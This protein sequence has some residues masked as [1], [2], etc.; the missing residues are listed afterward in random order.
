M[1]PATE[2]PSFKL[3]IPDETADDV[4]EALGGFGDSVD[5]P[6]L[7]IKV[8]AEYYTKY[9]DESGRPVFS[10]G[11][12]FVT[13]GGEPTPAQRTLDVVDSF[14]VAVRLSLATIGFARVFKR[15]VTRD[16]LRQEVE[17]LEAMAST[18]LSAAMIG[19]LRSFS[20][21]LYDANSFEGANLCRTANQGGLP[22]TKIVDH[23]KRVLRDL[24]ASL[25]D[26]TLGIGQAADLDNPNRLFECGWSWG[27]V[28]GAPPVKTTAEVGSQP[29][30]VAEDAP[31]LY[32]TVVALD[33][34][35]E[36]FSD[37]TR[38][39]GLLN[40][41]QGRL[42]RSLQA[43]WDITQRYWSRIA[44]FGDGRWPLE[45]IPWRTTDGV[46]SDY[47][48]LL[49]SSIVIQD[50]S[51][52]RASEADEGDLSRV[53]KVLE[54][55]AARARIT[56]REV[57]GGDS[58][59]A[60]HVPGFSLELV[61]SE[62]DG[63]QRLGWVLSDFSPQLLGSTIRV[64]GLLRTAALRGQLIELADDVWFRH[65]ARRR[66]KSQLWDQPGGIYSGIEST[67]EKPTWAFTQRVVACL[68]E[69]ADFVAGPPVPSPVLG[70][71]ATDLLA[72]A[73]HL[74]DQELLGVSAEAGPAMGPTLQTV[75][76]RL[77][78]A[79]LTKADRPGTASALA[80]D[81]LRE[82][83]LLAAARRVANEPS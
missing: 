40:E 71:L 6:R 34:I 45:D 58:A 50:L 48:S 8:L 30:G 54:N 69:A 67:D 72:E 74:F 37:R 53:G 32:F 52:Q 78:R 15:Q 77:R 35:Q 82:L 60:L 80:I 10:G 55:L 13:K 21:K 33:S 59:V 4:L 51:N 2:I 26:L 5:V 29:D 11:S 65:L 18:R 20:V 47:L 63:G 70:Q 42:A 17:A 14:S 19:L 62:K 46:E 61:G 75:R 7:L 83:D 28:E 12:Y 68:V 66:L 9:A 49:V 56:R 23:L 24:N 27:I 81:V 76:A 73:D 38:I 36:L 44:R 43:R 41:E 31:Y 22:A 64:A 57:M 3:D 1:G 16:S 39:L 25:R 79:H